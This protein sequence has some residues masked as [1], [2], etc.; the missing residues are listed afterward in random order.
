MLHH[1]LPKAAM[2]QRGLAKLDL[3]KGLLSD[4]T[5]GSVDAHPVDG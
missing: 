2:A 1:F 3:V 4:E 5:G